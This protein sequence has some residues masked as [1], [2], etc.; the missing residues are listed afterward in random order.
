MGSK[1]PLHLDIQLQS[2]GLMRVHNAHK[3]SFAE[4]SRSA[5]DVW[6]VL[7]PAQANEGE[8]NLRGK[9]VM[10]ADQRRRA[11]TAAAAHMIFIGDHDLAGATLHKMERDG[12]AHH[13]CPDDDNIGC[14]RQWIGVCRS[15]AAPR[16]RPVFQSRSA[17]CAAFLPGAPVT[18]PPG[19]APAPQRYSPSIGVRYCDQPGTGRIKNS[20]S[21]RKSPWKM[22]PSVNPY[23]RSRSSGVSTC[24]ARIARGTL[25]A[26]SAIFFTT[27]SPSNSRLSSQWPCRRR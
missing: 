17:W 19:C 16:N 7:E 15:H 10:H 1:L 21:R 27:R 4:V 5:H 12:R 25:G 22:L 8:F 6:P 18:P 20:C 9:A 2:S 26:Y 11:S 23:V 3:T 24:R 13:S 14:V